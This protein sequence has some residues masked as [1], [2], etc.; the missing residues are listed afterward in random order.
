MAKLTQAE[1]ETI[2]ALLDAHGELPHAFH[3]RLFP[4]AQ[5]QHAL[6][7]TSSPDTDDRVAAALAHLPNDAPD[8]AALAYGTE[9]HL[10]QVPRLWILASELP[11]EVI[12][13]DSLI[14]HFD[15]ARWLDDDEVPTVRS[16]VEHARRILATDLSYPIILS[17]DGRILDGMHR[18]AKA[19]ITNQETITAVR[20]EEN[21]VPDYRIP[22]A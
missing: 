4:P 1:V 12:R 6:D 22:Q 20:F 11:I 8:M 16:I 10:W 18:L 5:D 13:V 7:T 19:W 3:D 14:A 15:T 9:I 21:P 17:S 2:K